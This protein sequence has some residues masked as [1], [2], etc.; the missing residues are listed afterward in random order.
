MQQAA[1]ITSTIIKQLGGARFAMMVDAMF[2]SDEQSKQLMVAFRGSRSAQ[3]MVITKVWRLDP[4]DL[5]RVQFYIRTNKK[6]KSFCFCLWDYELVEDYDNV[7]CYMLQQVFT[8]VTGLA[9]RLST[10]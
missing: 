3:L 1:P 2:K 8:D 9:T 6:C 5:Y 10:R 7:S 4:T